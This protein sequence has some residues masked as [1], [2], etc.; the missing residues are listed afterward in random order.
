MKNKILTIFLVIFFAV[1]I[2]NVNEVF[3]VGLVSHA[4]KRYGDDNKLMLIFRTFTGPHD[5]SI[6]KYHNTN[7]TDYVQEGNQEWTYEYKGVKYPA[8]WIYYEGQGIEKPQTN[9]FKPLTVAFHTEP[10][11]EY[12]PYATNLNGGNIG[13]TEATGLKMTNEIASISDIVDNAKS[14]FVKLNSKN[15]YDSSVFYEV[16]L[17]NATYHKVDWGTGLVV[18]GLSFAN[19]IYLKSTIITINGTSAYVT[20]NVIYDNNV[21]G[22]ITKAN[23][24]G[25][26]EGCYVTKVVMSQVFR[27]YYAEHKEL[28]EE[29]YAVVGE[30]KDAYEVA[31]DVEKFF[32]QY[33]KGSKYYGFWGEGTLGSSQSNSMGSIANLYDNE[34]IFPQ[35]SKRTVLVRHIDVGTNTTISTDIVDAGTPIESTNLTLKANDETITGTAESENEYSRNYQEF[36]EGVISM[37]SSITKEALEDTAN[38]KCIG[39][40]IA[41][42]TSL[43]T[44]ENTIDTRI[45]SGQYNRTTTAEVSAKDMLDDGDYIVIDFYYTEYDKQVEV[46][47]IYL[48]KDGKVIE[49]ERQTIEPNE[50]AL[51]GDEEISRINTDKYIIEKYIKSLGKDITV[52]IAESLNGK[53][54]S[55]EV[56]YLGYETFKQATTLES[57]IGDKRS[58]DIAHY[59]D[60]AKITGDTVQ[61]NFYYY[62]CEQVEVNHLY[63]DKEGYV[64]ALSKQTIEPNDDAIERTMPLPTTLSKIN[65]DEYIKEVYVKRLKIA[66]QTRRA[67]SLEDYIAAGEISYKGYET[68]EQKVS[69]DDLIG[70]QKTDLETGNKAIIDGTILQVNY[71]YY[72]ANEVE[73]NHIYLNK[74]N[75]VVDISKQTIIPNDYAYI[76][77]ERLDRTNIDEYIREIYRKQLGKSITVRTADKLDSEASYQ[78]YEIF[79]ERVDIQTLVGT[80]IT[81]NELNKG[82]ETEIANDIIQVNF[83]YYMPNEVEVNHLYVDKDGKVL[84]IDEQTITPNKY[85]ILLATQQKVSRANQDLTIKE[86]YR[87]TVAST[88]TVRIADV[89]KDYIATGQIDVI[90]YEILQ[91]KKELDELIGSTISNLTTANKDTTVNITDEYE[92]VNFYYYAPNQV[93]VN[94]LYVDKDGK[95]VAREQQTILP[96]TSAKLLDIAT[97]TETVVSRVNTDTYI[98]EVYFKSFGKNIIVSKTSNLEINS[99]LEYLGYDRL[100]QKQSVADLI[101]DTITVDSTEVT[102]TIEDGIAQ[103]NFYYR[104]VVP[105]T[106]QI[107]VNHLYI[108]EVGNILDQSVQTITPNEFVYI[109]ESGEVTE[110]TLSRINTDEYVKEVYTKTIGED[111]QA[112]IAD[113]I[114]DSSEVAYKGCRVYDKIMDSYSLGKIAIDDLNESTTITIYEPIVQVNFYYTKVKPAEPEKVEIQ[115][116]HLYVDKYGYIIEESSQNIVPNTNVKILANGATTGR[117]LTR[118][119]GDTYVKEVYEKTVG[120]D[121]QTRI[122]DSIKT[123]INSSEIVYIGAEV[124]GEETDSYA[125]SARIKT[126]LNASKTINI[127]DGIAQVNFYYY[128]AEQ[129]E[130][131][132]LYVDKDG[133]VLAINEQKIE[134]NKYA[135]ANNQRINRTNSDRYIKEIYPKAVGV[136]ITVR[137]ADSLVSKIKSFT[138]EYMGYETLTRKTDVDNLI[139]KQKEDLNTNTTVNITDNIAQVNYYYYIIESEVAE[140]NYP[141]QPEP[142]KDIDGKVFVNPSPGNI[143]TTCLDTDDAISIVSVPSGSNATVGITGVPKYMAGSITAKYIKPKESELKKNI[144][145]TFKMA[146]E[147]KTINYYAIK[148]RTGYF[149]VTDMAVYQLTNTIVYDAQ[150]GTN[151]TIGTSIFDWANGKLSTLPS[152]MSLVVKLTGLNGRTIS[153]TVSAINNIDNYVT[154]YLKDKNNRTTYFYSNNATISKT[155]LS[156]SQLNTVDANGDKKIDEQDKVFADDKL[157]EYYTIWQDKIAVQAEKQAAYD[158]ALAERNRLKG[159]LDA[160]EAQLA[161]YKAAYDDAEKQK[162]DKLAAILNANNDLN[163]NKNELTSLQTELAEL[164]TRLEALNAELPTKQDA[165]DAAKA[166]FTTADN[167]L[168][169]LYGEYQDAIDERE[170]LESEANCDDTVDIYSEEDE[171]CK[172]AKEAYESNLENQ[173]VEIAKQAW[174]DYRDTTHKEAKDAKEKAES[175]LIILKVDIEETENKITATTNSIN[176]TEEEITKSET[177]TIPAMNKDYEDFINTVYTPA[178]NAYESYRDN[179]YATAKAN[180]DA[181]VAAKYLE[182]ALTALN[183]SKTETNTAFRNYNSYYSYSSTLNRNY[184][185]YKALYDE[186]VSITEDNAAA[187]LGLKLN[188]RVQN[189]SVSINNRLI[190]QATNNVANGVFDVQTMVNNRKDIPEVATVKPIISKD[191]YT[192]LGTEYTKESDYTNSNPIK[193]DK[194]NG[195][196]AL[197]GEAKYEAKTIIGNK[198]VKDIQDTIYYSD[199]ALNGTVVTF[200]LNTLKLSQ[201]YK[202][203]T[204]ATTAAEKYEQTTPINI[205]TPITVSA[206]MASD[207]NEIVNQSKNTQANTSMIQLNTSFTIDLANSVK[208]AEYNMSNTN[209]YSGGYYVKFDFDVH[210]V[211]VNGKKYNNGNIVSAG[212]WIGII[213]KKNN[214][215]YITA[216]AYGNLEGNGLDTVS[217]D[218]STYTVRAVAYNTTDLMLDKSIKFENLQKMIED[219]SE[220]KDSVFNICKNPSYF[221]ETTYNVILINRAFEFRI[222]DL[223]DVNWKSVFRT[224]TGNNTNKH[225]SVVYY[226]GSTRWNTASEESN[227]IIPRTTSQI[228]RT[229]LRILPLGPYK[230]TDSTYIKSPKLGYRFSFD[231]KVTGSYYNKQGDVR[232]NKKV[233]ITTKFY[234]ISKDGKTYLKEYDGSSEGIY[235]FYKTSAG[236]YVRIDENGGG[237]NLTFTPNDGYRYIED[238]D[239]STLSKKLVKLGN[240]RNLTLTHEMATVADNGSVITYYGEYKL[241]NSTIAVKVNA[242]GSY[243]IN[244]PLDNGYIGVVFDIVAYAGTVKLDNTTKDVQLSYSKDTKSQPN[245]SQWDYEGFLGYTNYGEKVSSTSPITM[246]LEN[247][248]WKITDKIYNEIKGSVILYDLDGRAATDYE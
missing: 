34:I 115:V 177:V 159:I 151:G 160:T 41:V 243:N 81:V 68:L 79:K 178:K 171:K 97:N 117:T 166:A 22:L 10:L 104:V 165:E 93:E 164:N 8:K 212:T 126:E 42:S 247:G 86:V 213:T 61:V 135:L 187:I 179:E 24:V 196:R 194:T 203:N 232:T 241:P 142:E 228:G 140:E 114:K 168:T 7:S 3:G 17:A 12:I 234:Y 92:Q 19:N 6:A 227:D 132:H 162:S 103:V 75:K 167:E 5:T 80:T 98:K 62:Q 88:I 30:Y 240:L 128:E 221:A 36:Y 208:P 33:K 138:V 107:E 57:L 101:G 47:H 152:N 143:S 113:S 51:S 238:S 96:N 23:E 100:E 60:N 74:E 70:K 149:K 153:N 25:K 200:K 53:I 184:Y 185:N 225:K 95:I 210:N 119:N 199:Q 85:A 50:K 207:T 188:V 183:K 65:I 67:D 94:H 43:N 108:D 89:L 110:E 116:N 123:K 105:T 31:R 215:A 180:Y 186:F 198:A 13:Y 15:N 131:N 237:Y 90:G 216:Q 154:A 4:W 148:Y 106:V 134:P 32:E 219:T 245:T 202:V 161:I 150:N 120:E 137:L 224:T 218:N 244:K 109:M 21:K 9:T 229:P 129:V 72:V 193:L 16:P 145:L 223:K 155:Y 124:F 191:I 111:L 170:R 78:G 233:D 99:E 56:Q 146:N 77:G 45:A 125:L 236:K 211:Y 205:Y 46:N 54:E 58:D 71:Y 87:K 204:T 172:Q 73:V 18:D 11:T 144:T 189:M 190:T 69:V 217:E 2:L 220:L 26:T 102:A 157:D 201:T 83:Y 214:R 141:E 133:I 40:N 121:L 231:M 192:N 195:I 158:A 175:D 28:M 84:E 37:E 169:R 91:Q 127:I 173:V 38:Y 82:T 197:A 222:T 230:N 59:S 242:D 235:L 44:A 76:E 181:H 147:T 118:I 29:V 176:S 35:Q 39:H 206:T 226:S 14:V 209:K 52:S 156:T 163:D 248:T 136:D 49:K 20:D 122:A 174:E 66:I 139:G 182:D 63:V 55:S 130:V 239:T 64:L 1:T 112:R 246:R 27:S 48:D